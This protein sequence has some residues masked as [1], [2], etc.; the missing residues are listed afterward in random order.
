[1]S[2]T[3]HYVDS[4]LDDGQRTL[5]GYTDDWGQKWQQNSS[6]GWER[7]G[8]QAG[9]SG[10]DPGMAIWNADDPNKSLPFDASP[11]QSYLNYAIPDT[12]GYANQDFY[13]GPAPNQSQNP[14]GI[15][16]L[17]NTS[18][19]GRGANTNPYATTKNRDALRSAAQ[20][21]GLTAADADRAA[22]DFAQTH[23]NQFGGPYSEASNPGVIADEIAKRL[24]SQAGRTYQGLTPEQRQE[25]VQRAT[26]YQNEVKKT[27]QEAWKNDSIA[28]MFGVGM[29]MLQGAWESGTNDGLPSEQALAGADNPLNTALQNK[30]HN[31]DWDPYANEYGLPTKK[32]YETANAQGYDT[33]GAAIIQNIAQQAMGLIGGGAVSEFA[34]MGL[35]SAGVNPSYAPAIVGGAKGA[36]GASNTAGSD[37]GDVLEGALSGAV[38]GGSGAYAEGEG[39]LAGAA[40]NY[41]AQ[42][43]QIAKAYENDNYSTLG[44]AAGGLLDG[45]SNTVTGGGDVVVGFG[46]TTADAFGHGSNFDLTTG[47]LT[48]N[49]NS[50]LDLLPNNKKADSMPLGEEDFWS[51]PDA[52]SSGD[53]QF[54][55]NQGAPSGSPDIFQ[56]NDYWNSLGLGG[57]G[58]YYSGAANDPSGGGGLSSLFPTTSDAYG[59]GSG[60]SGGGATGGGSGGGSLGGL[61][62]LLGGAAGGASGGTD[63]TRL[64]GAL[65]AAGLGAYGANQQANAYKDVATQYQNMGAPYRDRLAA[66]Y[67]NP[68]SFLTSKEVTTPVDQGTSALARSLSVQGNP[69][70][71][72][73]A[74]SSI[75]NYAT[76]Q[77]YG[78]LGE[79]KNRL[80]QMGGLSQ[81]AA[82]APQAQMAGVGAQGQVYGALG[83]GL[84]AATNPQTSMNDILMQ[85]ARNQNAG[86][87]A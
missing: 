39:S 49:T 14:W 24:F 35:E 78:R 17:F 43:Y 18:Y 68:D 12:T 45:G 65:G 87:L 55:A 13:S 82:A 46:G 58:D 72:G 25:M 2:L 61:G 26:N 1:M 15:E 41:A 30:L 32:N 8:G 37:S 6:G 22:L 4:G 23:F 66:L 71:S 36:Y 59:A 80:A 44:G 38:L 7:Y 20:R 77:L 9:A 74:L 19:A 85:M 69:A 16:Q 64:L 67:A 86:G 33:S 27:D 50:A 54:W 21:L 73:A 10:D 75:Q 34:G 62:S 51:N 57:I 79:E 83:Y 47:P 29:E 40:V 60:V 56:S 52:Y 31:E 42:G 63:Y 81:Y 3:P 48:S 70:G 28:G 11:Y 84:G 5:T 53:Y 76:N